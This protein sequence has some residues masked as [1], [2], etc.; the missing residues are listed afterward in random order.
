M[1]FLNELKFIF[2]LL[3]HWLLN[4]GKAGTDPVQCVTE[5]PDPRL[6]SVCSSGKSDSLQINTSGTRK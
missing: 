4:E 3:F 2:C 1:C 6:L 5:R